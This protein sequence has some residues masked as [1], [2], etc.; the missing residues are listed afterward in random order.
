MPGG[1]L[2]KAV[3]VSDRVS[4]PT[5]TTKSLGN[6]AVFVVSYPLHEP[7]VALKDCP[8]VPHVREEVPCAL[9]N[10]DNC[11]YTH[12]AA[13]VK[14]QWHHDTMVSLWLLQSNQHPLPHCVPY[15]NRACSFSVGLNTAPV[16]CER[17]RKSSRFCFNLLKEWFQSA[18]PL[19][20][21]DELRLWYFRNIEDFSTPRT[22]PRPAP[23]YAGIRQVQTVH[24][25]PP[26]VLGVAVPRIQC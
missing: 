10:N 17:L 16:T 1:K 24:K 5:R 9:L 22:T 6:P 4:H 25:Q 2:H 13:K 15:L 20:V 14:L 18:W 23:H 11:W 12:T 3:V 26:I 8:F 19:R 21:D 7:V